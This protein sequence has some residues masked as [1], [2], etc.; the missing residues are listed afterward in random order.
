MKQCTTKGCGSYAL[1]LKKQGIETT[2][3]DVCY[4]QDQAA[5]LRAQLEAVG[6]GGVSGRLMGEAP[7]GLLETL[8]ELRPMADYGRPG[9][10]DVDQA[11]Y[12]KALDA[13][14]AMLS[15]A[16]LPPTA[17]PAEPSKHS[18]EI[19]FK[20]A[21]ELLEMF[22]GEP[23]SI[24][25]MTG[26]GH[27]GKGLYAHYTEIP[28]EGAEYLGNADD[29]A[30]PTMQPQQSTPVQQSAA[31]MVTV[32]ACELAKIDGYGP[33]DTHGGLYDLRWSSGA[34]PEPVGDA[35]NMDYFPKAE[36]IAEA[37]NATGGTTP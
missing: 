27:S 1:N 30:V 33:D 9:S 31:D 36:R 32:I 15:A 26:D 37:I 16:P 22:A 11:R 24:T 34:N 2:L 13:A 6:A 5:D 21:T 17:Q 29:E 28:E 18:I 8:Q 4:W 14:I 20:Q 10:R 12:Q 23:T 25:L 3:C 19:D 35:W 7:A